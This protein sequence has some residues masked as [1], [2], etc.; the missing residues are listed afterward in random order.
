MP[1]LDTY[2]DL[3]RIALIKDG[4]KIT[5]D[6][7]TID[8]EDLTIYADLGAEK[9]MAAQKQE[10]KIAIEI[11]AFLSPSP[12]TE[13]ERA[14]GQYYLYSTFLAKQEP[15]RSLYLAIPERVYNNFFQRLSIQLFIQERGIS[16]FVFNPE[17]EEIVLWKS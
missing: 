4:W 3:V 12:V 5:Q 2:H 6:P 11:K 13:L 7:L 15:E 16:F 9:F 10:K 8:F 14:I 1:R 17:R